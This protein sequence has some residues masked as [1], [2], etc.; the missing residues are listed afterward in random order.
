MELD[1]SGGGVA[2]RR[3]IWDAR[4]I[5][6]GEKAAEEMRRELADYSTLTGILRADMV[7]EDQPAAFAAILKPHGKAVEAADGR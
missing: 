7:R 1:P 4:G 3:L 2:L 6:V 5:D